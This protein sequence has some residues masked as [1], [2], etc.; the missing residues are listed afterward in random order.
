M[1]E[2]LTLATGPEPPPPAPPVLGCSQEG[3]FGAGGPLRGLGQARKMSRVA[4][5]S[6]NWSLETEAAQVMVSQLV[7]SFQE[8]SG[9]SREGVAYQLRLVRKAECTFA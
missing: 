5:Q 4:R 9:R 7:L 2:G 8:G 1:G 3:C 6:L